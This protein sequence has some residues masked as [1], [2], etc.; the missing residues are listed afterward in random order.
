ME[1]GL[2]LVNAEMQ[3]VEQI[4]AATRVLARGRQVTVRAACTRGAVALAGPLA[5]MLQTD[6]LIDGN[7]DAL[8]TADDGGRLDARSLQEHTAVHSIPAVNIASD[9]SGE[10]SKVQYS[11]RIRRA[12]HTVYPTFEVVL[13]SQSSLRLTVALITAQLCEQADMLEIAYVQGLPTV[14]KLFKDE[15]EVRKFSSARISDLAPVSQ[16]KRADNVQEKAANLPLEL[17][18]S[19]EIPPRIR[20]EVRKM[21]ESCQINLQSMLHSEKMTVED[22]LKLNEIKENIDK[23]VAATKQ[24]LNQSL[25]TVLKEVQSLETAQDSLKTELISMARDLQT[26]AS[27]QGHLKRLIQTVSTAFPSALDRF[28]VQLKAEEQIFTEQKAELAD[29]LKGQKPSKLLFFLGPVST[30]EGTALT[31]TVTRSKSYYV[32]GKVSVLGPDGTTELLEL[33]LS[34]RSEVSL[35]SVLQYKTGEY[36]VS[37]LQRD[38]RLA[39]NVVTFTLHE[40]RSLPRPAKP[41]KEPYLASLLY[42]S[43]GTIEDIE[44]QI[45]AQAGE[46]GLV[47]FR[48]LAVMWANADSSRIQEFLDICLQTLSAGE[49]ETRARLESSGFQFLLA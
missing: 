47:C 45:I 5:A 19:G 27:S 26:V 38:G 21:M 16:Q 31:T 32:E 12:L 8:R 25:K 34:T 30:R 11:Q 41:R 23:R 48:R 9:A 44:H 18:H 3:L 2:L 28:S 10:D 42:N 40:S 4:A 17:V 37:V 14:A 15:S 46:G 35:G 36:Q 43:L 39:S 6:W 29:L 24:E 13:T 7:W 49:E 20:T 22:R 1:R 33:D